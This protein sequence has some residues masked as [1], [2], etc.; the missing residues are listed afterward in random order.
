MVRLDAWSHMIVI[1]MTCVPTLCNAFTFLAIEYSNSCMCED[2]EMM[3]IH[4]MTPVVF[5][6]HED[7]VLRRI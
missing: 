7:G 1:Y 6:M 4:Q 5:D 3:I 2:A